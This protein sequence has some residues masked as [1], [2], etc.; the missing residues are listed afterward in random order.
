M[1]SQLTPQAPVYQFVEHASQCAPVLEELG[2]DFCCGGNQSLEKAC[3][4]R[5]LDVNEVFNRLMAVQPATGGGT[6]PEMA[7]APAEM[8]DHIEAS[9]HVYLKAAMPRIQQLIEKVVAAHGGNHPE[10]K[11]V[12][13]LFQELVDDLGPHLMKEERV[14]F[15]MIRKLGTSMESGEFHC[16]SIRSPIRVMLMEHDTAG[17]LL[18]KIKE[19]TGTYSLPE[20]ACRSYEL[21]MK[22][23]KQ[24]TEDTHLHIHKENNLLFPAVLEQV[25]EA[26]M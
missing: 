8:V 23:L 3:R 2:I 17:A 25:E 16:G 20:D 9:H 14:L 7:G 12:E 26:P 19:A 13:A 21:L 22:E 18:E 10:L 6:E 24:F 5:G 15:P 1:K 4:A 11:E